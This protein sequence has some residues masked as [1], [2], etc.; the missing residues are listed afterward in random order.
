MATSTVVV[1]H[2]H[3]QLI[4]KTVVYGLSPKVS[5][6][7]HKPRLFKLMMYIGSL[8]VFEHRSIDCKLQG[9]YLHQLNQALHI[10]RRNAAF[11]FHPPL[12]QGPELSAYRPRLWVFVG[13]GFFSLLRVKSSGKS[14]KG[15]PA[16]NIISTKFINKNVLTQF[17]YIKEVIV[18]EY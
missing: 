14:P 13:D 1:P 2:W 17:E 16:V 3:W 7:C 12:P 6:I 10:P 5:C 8:I 9:Y 15:S 18:T 11:K 4:N